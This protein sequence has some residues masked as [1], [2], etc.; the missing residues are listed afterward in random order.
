MNFND[1]GTKIFYR[2]Q[3]KSY[4]G[5][6]VIISNKYV[7]YNNGGE[8]EWHIHGVQYASKKNFMYWCLTRPPAIR[9][10]CKYMAGGTGETLSQV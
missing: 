9:Y 5:L 8:G 7:I 10:T 3:K 6:M 4:K 1:V 2:L